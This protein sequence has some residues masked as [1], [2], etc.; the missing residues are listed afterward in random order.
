VVVLAHSQTIADQGEKKVGHC[1]FH[2]SRETSST[3]SS[4]WPHRRFA[5]GPCN[6]D[7]NG[8]ACWSLVAQAPGQKGAFVPVSSEPRRVDTKPLTTAAPLPV[9]HEAGD[10]VV[11][12]PGT[13]RAIHISLVPES[14]WPHPILG[15]GE[16]V[17][18]SNPRV[19][20]KTGLPNLH[21]LGA[22]AQRPRWCR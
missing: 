10:L 18:P 19:T 1:R 11:P 14:G 16:W 8:A 22:S 4:P 7:P 15:T 6:Q 3:A 17:A 2:T 12:S 9:G 13:K 21:Q 5:P 20:A